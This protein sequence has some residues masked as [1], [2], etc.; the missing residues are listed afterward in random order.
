MAPTKSKD[1]RQGERNDSAEEGEHD[2]PPGAE[3]LFSRQAIEAKFKRTADLTTIQGVDTIL[4]SDDDPD[5][6]AKLFIERFNHL[7]GQANGKS[8]VLIW[9]VLNPAQLKTVIDKARV[10]DPGLCQSL[11]RHAIV[12]IMSEGGK[13]HQLMETAFAEPRK[14]GALTITAFPTGDA[15]TYQYYGHRKPT[16]AE[17]WSEG[18]RCVELINLP[19]PPDALISF[20][21]EAHINALDDSSIKHGDKASPELAFWGISIAKIENL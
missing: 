6:G 17:G 4:F 15:G 10:L 19:E 16:D 7:L 9:L 21:H 12:A 20:L 13:A 5:D 1:T 14:A 11:N 2:E 3:L 18:P 8:V